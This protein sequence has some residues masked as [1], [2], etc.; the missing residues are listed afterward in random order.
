MPDSPSPKPIWKKSSLC[1]SERLADSE[2]GK[3]G[4]RAGLYL[5]GDSEKRKACGLGAGPACTDVHAPV[6]NPEPATVDLLTVGEAS[7]TRGVDIRPEYLH[8]LR[9]QF[10]LTD[11]R[12]SLLVRVASW[13]RW[14]Q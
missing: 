10:R 8:A 6:S 2:P 12:A 3:K 1:G 7:G 11:V 5:E 9:G 13:G 14:W 4:A